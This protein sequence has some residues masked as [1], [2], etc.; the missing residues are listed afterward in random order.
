MSHTGFRVP[1]HGRSVSSLQT[2]LHSGVLILLSVFLTFCDEEFPTAT[3]PENVLVGGLTIDSPDTVALHYDEGTHQYFLN[4]VLFFNVDVTNVYQ[5]LLSGDALVNGTITIQ[6]FGEI[7]RVL[8]VPLTTGNL[9]QPPVFH[10]T[11]SLAPGKKAEFTSRWI[12]YA[13]DGNI[14]FEGLPSTV[15]GSAR[16]Y[17]PITF[18]ASA[19]VQLFERVQPIK[20]GHLEFRL[21]FRVR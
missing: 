14:V 2:I 8:V 7:P 11:I 4:S 21:V 5:N 10:R 15:V 1:T 16:Y 13:T 18:L 19:E 17:G 20:F 6:S 12:P 3:T 9:V